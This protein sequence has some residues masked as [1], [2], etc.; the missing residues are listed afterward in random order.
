MLKSLSKVHTRL[1]RA[2]RAFVKQE[3]ILAFLIAFA[4]ITLGYLSLVLLF[5]LLISQ[6]P[7]MLDFCPPIDCSIFI[8]LGIFKVVLLFNYQCFVCFFRNSLFIISYSVLF[9]KNFFLSFKTF[10]IPSLFS[11]VLYINISLLHCQQLFSFSLLFFI[12]EFS[13]VPYLIIIH[14]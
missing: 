14:S 4:K 6:R 12:Y 5:G 9:V 11:N 7:R 13:D 10:L 1:R 3:Y 8:S 2:S